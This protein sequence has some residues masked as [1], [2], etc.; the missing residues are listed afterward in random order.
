L[1]QKKMSEYASEL[2][3]KGEG[4]KTTRIS[5]EDARVTILEAE[6]AQNGENRIVDPAVEHLC[7]FYTFLNEN[8]NGIS[9]SMLPLCALFDDDENQELNDNAYSNQGDYPGPHCKIKKGMQSLLDTLVNKLEGTILLG[10]EVLR[11]LRLE[12]SVRVETSSGLVVIADCCICTLPLGCLKSSASSIFQPSLTAEKLE[13]ISAISAGNYKK[14]FLTFSSIFWPT[15]VPLLALIRDGNQ[16]NYLLINSLWAKHGVP[17]MEAVL[18][19]QLGS[20]AIGKSNE[21][22]MQFVTQFLADTMPID[23]VEEL[24]TDCHVTRWE[25][26]PYTKGS[27]SSFQLGTLERHVDALGATEWEGRL[28]FAG[29]A[30]ES[31]HMGSVHAAL[32]SG[33]KAMHLVQ[34]IFDNQDTSCSKPL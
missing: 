23:N 27:Y 7:L 2:F 6:K 18:C 17:C 30:T 31:E 14:V 32:I 34:Q 25:E 9:S 11:I 8:W 15:D 29:E 19:G 22:L 16:P 28:I 21:E 4:M 24:C 13:A 10:Q 5:A 1:I 26:D 20:W 3:A 33:Q 12:D